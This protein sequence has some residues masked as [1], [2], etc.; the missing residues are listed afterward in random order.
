MHRLLR[1][2][3]AAASPNLTGVGQMSRASARRSSTSGSRHMLGW[4]WPFSKRGEPS[5]ADQNQRQLQNLLNVAYAA[6]RS[7]DFS[8][9]S[10][11]RVAAALGE[12][13]Y[14]PIVWRRTCLLHQRI[15]VRAH[16]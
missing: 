9:E 4:A 15:I 5:T 2:P 16:H 11:G 3:G 12:A 13:R 1:I 6:V 10:T 14:C 8:T 7:G